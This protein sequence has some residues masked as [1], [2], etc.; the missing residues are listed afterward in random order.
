M[1]FTWCR[2]VEDE[3]VKLRLHL[4]VQFGPQAS[5]QVGAQLVANV[6]RAAA[7]HHA[8]HAAIATCTYAHH[9]L[10]TTVFTNFVTARNCLGSAIPHTPISLIRA[11]LSANARGNAEFDRR[12]RKLL[13]LKNAVRTDFAICG[14]IS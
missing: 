11:A 12:P 1:W 7:A 2:H 5:A 10:F 4:R 14:T 13:V 3:R 9:I 6:L 8:A